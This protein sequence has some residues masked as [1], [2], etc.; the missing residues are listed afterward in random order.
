MAI[1][2]QDVETATAPPETSPAGTG[3]A[4]RTPGSTGA[5]QDGEGESKKDNSR[6]VERALDRIMSRRARL[7]T[8]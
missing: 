1:V 6:Q 2:I 5:K 4:A 8:Y 7:M 3:D